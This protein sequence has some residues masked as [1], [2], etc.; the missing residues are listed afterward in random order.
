MMDEFFLL[1]FIF[2]WNKIIKQKIIF[3][4]VYTTCETST[5]VSFR[6]LLQKLEHFSDGSCQNSQ[7]HTSDLIFLGNIVLEMKNRYDVLTHGAK[8]IHNL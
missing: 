4:F 6:F 5:F 1:I 8:I 3:F 7:R 2:L